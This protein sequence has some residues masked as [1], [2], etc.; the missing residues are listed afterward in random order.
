MEEEGEGGPSS[1][2]SSRSSK[3]D[4]FHECSQFMR[5]PAMTSVDTELDSL[6]DLILSSVSMCDEAV[7]RELL[8]NILLVGGGAMMTGLSQRLTAELNS[9]TPAS[10][11]PKLIPHVPLLPIEKQSAAWIGGSILS[12]CGSFQQEWVTKR[13]YEEY[14]GERLATQRFTR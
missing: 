6:T 10:I 11:K 2:S 5:S 1:S 12:I 9:L 13:E 3:V 4:Y 7:R 8:G 14:G